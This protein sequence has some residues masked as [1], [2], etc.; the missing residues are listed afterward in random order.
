MRSILEELSRQHNIQPKEKEILQ[1]IAINTEKLKEDFSKCQKKQLLRI[2]DD[3]DLLAESQ[4]S[5]SFANG[6]R[7]GVLLM[8]EIFYS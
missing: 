6:M 7:Y 5:E 1:R 2:V 3:K 8:I 4:A